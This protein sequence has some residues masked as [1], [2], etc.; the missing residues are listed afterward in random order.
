M[1]FGPSILSDRWCVPPLRRPPRNIRFLSF[2]RWLPSP[3]SQT[4]SGSGALL[5]SIELAV[6]A[7]EL[8]AG[9]AYYDGMDAMV[10]VA[11]GAR[12]LIIQTTSNKLSLAGLDVG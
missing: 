6:A 1:F 5:Q 2:A 9:G 3:Q 12:K 10:D 11:A 7:E 4:R 8:G